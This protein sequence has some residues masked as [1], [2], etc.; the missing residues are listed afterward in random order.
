M[1]KVISFKIAVLAILGF[2]YT[3]V[4]AQTVESTAS[5]WVKNGEWRNGVKLNLY[6]GMDNVEF[7]KQYH[8]NK[9]YWDKAFAFLANTQLDTLTIG[10]HAIDGENVFATVSE[11]PTKDY[12]KTAWEAHKKYIDLHL[13]IRGKERIGV[14]NAASATVTNAYDD[15]KDVT[16]FDVNTKG[17]YY[18]ADT[19]TLLIFF[20]DNS[21]RPGIH[22]DGYDT[23]KKLVIKIKVAD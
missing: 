22:V 9:A 19:G 16:N 1:K 13:M 18:V 21:H 15:V 7:E 3:T 20:P 11:G 2:V 10:K 5:T 14:M 4:S 12:N 6:A 23:V 17:D 8:S